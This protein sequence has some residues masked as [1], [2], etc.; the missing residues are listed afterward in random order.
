M[1]T[2]K[3]IALEHYIK[4]SELCWKTYHEWLVGPVQSRQFYMS[5][6][7]KDAVCGEALLHGERR[8]REASNGI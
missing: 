5:R 2:D 7:M 4:A 3:E 1:K 6:H 8:K